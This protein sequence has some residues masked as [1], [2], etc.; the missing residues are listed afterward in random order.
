MAVRI[1]DPIQKSGHIVARNASEPRHDF[2]VDQRA[3]LFVVPDVAHTFVTK[4]HYAFS[5]YLGRKSL[6]RS[7]VFR[8]DYL[9]ETL[10]DLHEFGKTQHEMGNANLLDIYHH[11]LRDAPSFKVSSPFAEKL[12]STDEIT[13]EVSQCVSCVDSLFPDLVSHRQFV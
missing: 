7:E 2:R 9:I 6:T 13:D 11:H 8:W 5:P 3:L 4:F 1:V 10:I 12:S